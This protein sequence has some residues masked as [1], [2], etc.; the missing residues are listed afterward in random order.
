[1]VYC[2][3]SVVQCCVVRCSN[4]YVFDGFRGLL[5]FL[6][7]LTTNQWRENK[8]RYLRAPIQ[9]TNTNSIII[10]NHNTHSPPPT[11]TTTTLQVNY[12]SH[13]EW[14]IHT[15]TLLLLEVRVYHYVMK[16]V[17]ITT[18]NIII[19][20]LTLTTHTHYYNYYR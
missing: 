9:H 6:F 7:D 3:V 17:M 16:T 13:L 20:T 11:T 18:V 19:L 4:L 5:K 15:I 2:S 12:F 10:Y 14:D 8:I 1:M